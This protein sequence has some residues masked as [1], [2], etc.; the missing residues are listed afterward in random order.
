MKPN[1]RAVQVTATTKQP[2]SHP[3]ADAVNNRKSTAR[4]PANTVERRAK[5]DKLCKLFD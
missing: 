5:L 1:I 3:N 4:R 2:S